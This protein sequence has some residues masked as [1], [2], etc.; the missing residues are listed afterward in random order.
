MKDGVPQYVGLVQDE[1]GNYY[2]I[3]SSLEAVKNRT[4]GIG[5]AKTNGLLPAGKYQ[6]G[7][8][9]KMINPPTI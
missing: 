8:D 2:Y 6:F 5:E 9:G 4:Y 1:E 7:E 3:N